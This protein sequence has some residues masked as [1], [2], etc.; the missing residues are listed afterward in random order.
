[1]SCA[2]RGPAA[3]QSS[4]QPPVQPCAAKPEYR[5]FDFRVGEWDVQVNG[6]HAGTNIVQL[7]LENAEHAEIA[8]HAESFHGFFACSAV[9][10]YS[11]FFR[12]PEKAPPGDLA[13]RNTAIKMNFPHLSGSRAYRITSVQE[14]L[15]PIEIRANPQGRNHESNRRQNMRRA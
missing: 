10:A 6:Q 4:P 9:S 5:Q 14:S 11:A 15:P 2:S 3:S 7:I 8:E 1:M 13:W 12:C